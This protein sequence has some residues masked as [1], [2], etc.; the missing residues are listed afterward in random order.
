[1]VRGPM[2]EIERKFL[3]RTLPPDL[4]THPSY[5]IQQGYLVPTGEIEVRLRGSG[6]KLT[7]TFKK[8]AGLVREE[9][10]LPLTPEQWDELWPLTVGR[11]LRKRRYE[12][13][14][15]EWTVEIDV[16]AGRSTGLVVAEVEFPSEAAAY[17]FQPPEWLGEEITGQPKYSNPLLATE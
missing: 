7:L 1:M 13:P 9:I 6:E 16:Y 3:I 14:C 10:N 17:L 5:E 15:G 11:R 4:E 12:V 2:L 8:R